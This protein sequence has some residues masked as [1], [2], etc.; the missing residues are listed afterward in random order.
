[1]ERNR[2]I[3]G[4]PVRNGRAGSDG[5]GLPRRPGGQVQQKSWTGVSANITDVRCDD[6]VRVDLRSEW[7][8]LSVMLEK[9]AGVSRFG[10]NL[11]A[12]RSTSQDAPRPLSLIPARSGAYGQATG[13]RFIRHLMLQFDGAAWRAMLEDE[14]DF[15]K[16]LRRG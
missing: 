10:R 8:R 2:L 1:M 6:Y 7:T 16:A 5:A 13:V 14:V 11:G 9:S 4:T 12:N 3:V 15:S